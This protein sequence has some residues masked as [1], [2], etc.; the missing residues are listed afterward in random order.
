MRACLL[1]LFIL[2]SLIGLAPSA[3]ASVAGTWITADGTAVLELRREG[4]TVHVQLRAVPEPFLD[5]DAPALDVKN[6]DPALRGR[7]LAGLELGVLRASR[8]ELAGRLYDPQSGRRFSVATSAQSTSVLKLRA[9]V[10]LR[11]LGRSLLWVRPDRWRART[12]ALLA[13]AAEVER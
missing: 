13:A 10:G 11:V 3:C 5:A 9:W 6:P 4:D 1:L 2:I 7:S 8:G 12:D